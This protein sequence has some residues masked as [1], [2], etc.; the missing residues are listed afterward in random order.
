M[1]LAIGTHCE[2]DPDEC[3]SNPCAFG[4]C[5]DSQ[6]RYICDCDIGYAGK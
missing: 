3:D 2:T 6:D 4:E 5:I 1:R